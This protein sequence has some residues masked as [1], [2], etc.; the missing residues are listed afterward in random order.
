MGCHPHQIA[1]GSSWREGIPISFMATL[2]MPLL[3]AQLGTICG[4]VMVY[5]GLGEVM[6]I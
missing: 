3:Y 6:L 4:N 2:P 1:Q 5:M